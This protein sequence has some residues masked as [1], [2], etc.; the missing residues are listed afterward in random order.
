MILE[1]R[2]ILN[3]ITLR[4]ICLFFRKILFIYFSVYVSFVRVSKLLLYYIYFEDLIIEERGFGVTLHSNQ[5]FL[6][7]LYE[8]C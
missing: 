8:M 3:H 6:P 7:S 1:I 5:I 4:I 2:D